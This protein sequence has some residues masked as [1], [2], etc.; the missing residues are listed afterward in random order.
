MTTKTVH[1]LSDGFNLIVE[2]DIDKGVISIYTNVGD[3]ITVGTVM[4]GIT[5][6]II[7]ILNIDVLDNYRCMG[8]GELLINVL[9]TNHLDKDVDWGITTELGEYLKDKFS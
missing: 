4:Y 6:K 8:I 9:I 3:Y 1:N 7:Q 5:T 2:E